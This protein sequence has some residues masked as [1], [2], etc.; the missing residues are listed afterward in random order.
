M[1]GIAESYDDTRDVYIYDPDTEDLYTLDSWLRDADLSTPFYV[2]G[3]VD[4]HY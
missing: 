3:V 2:G 4:Y 1:R